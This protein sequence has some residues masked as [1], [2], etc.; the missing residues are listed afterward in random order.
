M[1]R[2]ICLMF[3]IM[4]VVTFC[5]FTFADSK[6]DA[7]EKEALLDAA[8]RNAVL[9]AAK[10]GIGIKRIDAEEITGLFGTYNGF[11]LTVTIDNVNGRKPPVR[12][13]ADKTEKKDAE[14]LFEYMNLYY[15]YSALNRA[16]LRFTFQAP[17]YR[18]YVNEYSKKL[19]ECLFTFK[20][21]IYTG[22]LR[23]SGTEET[24]GEDTAVFKSEN[25]FD[26]DRTYMRVRDSINYYK[27]END[28]LSSKDF[29]YSYTNA[30]SKKCLALKKEKEKNRIKLEKIKRKKR[31]QKL[32]ERRNTQK[33]VLVKSLRLNASAYG[34]GLYRIK[35]KNV[36]K[37]GVPSGFSVKVI[38]DSHDGRSLA[39]NLISKKARKKV[40]S[41]ISRYNDLEKENI[42]VKFVYRLKDAEGKSYYTRYQVIK[43]TLS[44]EESAHYYLGYYSN[45]FKAIYHQKKKP[46]ALYRTIDTGRAFYRKLKKTNEILGK[47]GIRERSYVCLHSNDLILKS[48]YTPKKY[49]GNPEDYD[50]ARD[51]WYA[52]R[53]LLNEDEAYDIYDEATGYEYESEEW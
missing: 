48:S 53:D 21:D 30:F 45:G 47:K 44:G 12:K 36:N 46:K 2:L 52:N 14:R 18:Y 34:I 19:K 37:K 10:R 32:K 40:F 1:K 5:S 38:M 13:P 24:D 29:K 42:R 11:E 49:R 23:A 33:K 16:K 43:K 51:F 31:I 17:D 4:T 22:T 3:T 28:A 20:A 25:G 41:Y 26:S 35:T 27:K 15:D 50:S 8:K 9:N 6:L 39:C 7:Y